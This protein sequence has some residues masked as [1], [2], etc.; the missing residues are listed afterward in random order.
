MKVLAESNADGHGISR[1]PVSEL[2]VVQSSFVPDNLHADLNY[3]IFLLKKV[4]LH[5]QQGLMYS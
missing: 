1:L 5:V 4:N 2:M 3:S